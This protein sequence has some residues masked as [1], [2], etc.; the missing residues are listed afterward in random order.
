MLEEIRDD[1]GEIAGIL[2]TANGGM[3]EAM[4]GTN[5]DN[6][7]QLASD[8]LSRCGKAESTCIDIL[9][10][11]SAKMINAITHPM[12]AQPTL[13]SAG[14]QLIITNAIEEHERK[15][16]SAE[17]KELFA[18]GANAVQYMLEENGAWTEF[19]LE[20]SRDFMET[21]CKRFESYV[22]HDD[23]KDACH[24]GNSV[25]ESLTK[26]K[27]ALRNFDVRSI[28]DL[29]RSNLVKNVSSFFEKAFLRLTKLGDDKFTERHRVIYYLIN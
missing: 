14:A 29:T 15:R 21:Y 5:R 24:L 22:T 6:M 26:V 8:L 3:I 25:N 1:I 18:V 17:L 20:L 9:A 7:V 4:Y 2:Q 28:K 12:F 23:I 10:K 19:Q 11:I 27:G 16:P 13:D